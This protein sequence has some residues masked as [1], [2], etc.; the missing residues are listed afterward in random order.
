M[1]DKVQNS[2]LFVVNAA[3]VKEKSAGNSLRK[4][5]DRVV[6]GIRGTL[7]QFPCQVSV[8]KWSRV[9]ERNSRLDKKKWGKK[10]NC[11]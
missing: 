3:R 10:K 5:N 1:K 8:Y 9:N 2:S 7:V 11:Y 6:H 4:M